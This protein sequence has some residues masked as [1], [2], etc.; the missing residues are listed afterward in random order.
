MNTSK[1]NVQN[2]NETKV[3]YKF[4]IGHTIKTDNL[5][6]TIINRK[7]IEHISVTKDGLSTYTRHKAV[8]QYKCN[9][10]GFSNS[11]N[12]YAHGELKTNQW[13]SQ[14]SLE[15]KIFCPCCTNRFVVT[16][17]NDIF[18]KNKEL[19]PFIANEFDAKRL[20][21]GS[22]VKIDVKCDI[23]GKVSTKQMSPN[24]LCRKLNCSI[25]VPCVCRDG[26]YSTER[27]FENF[28]IYNNVDYIK[29]YS[30]AWANRKRYDFLLNNKFIIEIDGD[31]HST[32]RFRDTEIEN[33]NY[34][35]NLAYKN[36]FSK[37][38]YESLN[39]YKSD[40]KYM[41]NHI[42][43]SN[44]LTKNYNLDFSEEC[45]K[46]C[47]KKSCTSLVK[48][49][50]DYYESNPTTIQNLANIFDINVCTAGK[51]LRL[52]RD[53]GFNSYKGKSIA[54]IVEKDGEYIGTFNSIKELITTTNYGLNK[55]EIY[56]QMKNIIPTCKNG[57]VVKKVS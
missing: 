47:V 20:S 27:F 5:N 10:C 38:T 2:E 9:E 36:G 54:V 42:K 1:S 18:T 53:L 29:E 41:W 16:G 44:I 40:F 46:Y 3:K 13:I 17:I 32:C 37:E 52:G 21:R 45:Y 25:V 56:K 30:P 4:E 11:E 15:K 39:F 48:E 57:I 49:L 50:S 26:K 35:R 33:D 7:T 6:I 55:N 24:E 23:C 19:L 43:T 14:Q 8:Y 31:Q 34:K 22:T 51:Y 12:Y 28:L